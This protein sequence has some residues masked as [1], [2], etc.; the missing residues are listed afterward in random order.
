MIFNVVV[1][2]DE[3]LALD[4]ISDYVE[5]TPFLSLKASFRDCF[6]AIN[7]LNNHHVD[8]LLL[9]INMPILNGIDL[10]LLLPNPPKVVFITAHPDYALQG[11]KLNALDYLVKPVRYP[12]FLKAANKLVELNNA[13]LAQ[14]QQSDVPTT[15]DDNY[16]FVKVDNRY[17]R[18]K[19]A[20]IKFIEAYGD[21]VTYLLEQGKWLSF[22]TMVHALENLPSHDFIRVHRS[23]IVN[24]RHVNMIHRDHLLIG[25]Q[26]ISISKSYY[27]N[28]QSRLVK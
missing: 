16:I 7:Y 23:Y 24:L 14:Q 2:D 9:D 3:K 26:D 6:A 18:I 15:S 20:E 10:M 17:E 21:Y 11:F 8:L 25:M 4:L 1:V 5:Q 13:P 28:L 22:K 27:K 19:L 12:Q